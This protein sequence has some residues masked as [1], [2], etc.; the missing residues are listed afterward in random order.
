[1]PARRPPNVEESIN[2]MKIF[3][4]MKEWFDAKKRLQG[5][6]EQIEDLL[7]Q[8]DTLGERNESL[9]FQNKQWSGEK[10]LDER[11]TIL[12]RHLLASIDL[13]DVRDDQVMNPDERKEWVARVASNYAVTSKIVKRFLVAQEEF[14]A[15]MAENEKQLMF[16]RGTINGIMLIQEELENAFK[17][18]MANIQ[19]EKPFD[20]TK[21]FPET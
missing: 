15:R 17:E 8:I 20:K 12:T 9:E 18:H 3:E 4:S 13:I 2:N 11:A 19:P 16:A 7:S 5:A 6:E 21:L 10:A 14:I 1:M